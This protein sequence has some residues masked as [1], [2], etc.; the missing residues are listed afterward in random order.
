MDIT[1]GR[2]KFYFLFAILDNVAF[3]KDS[4]LL[5]EGVG[6]RAAFLCYE[7]A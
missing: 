2:S 5:Q 6:L 3:W 4:L 7:I 1:E